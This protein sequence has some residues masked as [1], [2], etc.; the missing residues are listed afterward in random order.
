MA[1]KSI[2]HLKQY[3][4]RTTASGKHSFSEAFNEVSK[5]SRVGLTVL[6]EPLQSSIVIYSMQLELATLCCR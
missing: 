1:F 2:A 6:N 5:C 3:S 4:P